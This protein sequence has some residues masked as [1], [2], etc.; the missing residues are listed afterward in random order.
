M[1]AANGVSIDFQTLLADV[2]RILPASVATQ[3]NLDP[4]VLAVG[5]KSQT[6]A[7]ERI[8]QE[9]AGTPHI[10]NLGHGIRQE[11]PVAHVENLISQIRASR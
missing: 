8:L 11:T 4:M 5:G 10:F 3:G 6:G 7:V 9:T 2:R 1:T